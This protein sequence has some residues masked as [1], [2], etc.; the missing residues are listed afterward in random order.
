MAHLTVDG[1]ELAAARRHIDFCHGAELL[2]QIG[3][4]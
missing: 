4:K 3:G 1:D 2:E